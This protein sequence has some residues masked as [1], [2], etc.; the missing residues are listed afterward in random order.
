MQVITSDHILYDQLRVHL[1][2]FQTMHE[3]IACPRKYLPINRTV[4][5][6]QSRRASHGEK[7]ASYPKSA[8]VYNQPLRRNPSNHTHQ[9]W[10][11]QY[12]VNL[13]MPSND[14]VGS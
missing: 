2:L 6:S 11:F 5:G 10:T 14:C 13:C 4:K 1:Q 7:A 3:D 12:H 8:D 9:A